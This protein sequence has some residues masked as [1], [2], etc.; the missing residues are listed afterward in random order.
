MQRPPTNPAADAIDQMVADRIEKQRKPIQS[1]SNSKGTFLRQIKAVAKRIQ[2]SDWEGTKPVD[3]V[4]LFAW[5]HH[6][7]YGIWPED[8]YVTATRTKAR[9][10]AGRMVKDAFGGDMD[11]ALN[12]M[13]WTW[14]RE[15]DFEEWRRKN[16]KPGKVMSWNQQFGAARLRT[17]YRINKERGLE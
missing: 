15:G 9:M 5:C 4:A 13:R 10:L 8:L 7:I 11:E 12:F 1:K 3:L 2:S 17:E 6:Q 14:R 16:R